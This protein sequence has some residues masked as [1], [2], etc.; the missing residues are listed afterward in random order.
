M[1][2]VSVNGAAEGDLETVGAL[3]QGRYVKLTDAERA[4]G[5]IGRCYEFSVKFYV[6][7]I[8]E[9]VET[10]DV[11]EALACLEGSGVD[12]GGVEGCL[13]KF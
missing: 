9:A 5:C 7:V 8:V 2:E 3:H 12:P 1:V 13:V 6:G 10:E 11:P 4:E